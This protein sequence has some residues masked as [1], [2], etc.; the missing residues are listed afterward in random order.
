M[1]TSNYILSDVIEPGT[2][3]SSLHAPS[4]FA[5]R[6][7]AFGSKSSANAFGSVRSIASRASQRLAQAK[8]TLQV[9]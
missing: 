2:Y 9:L 3:K 8:P 6:V 5:S 4:P 7:S 1:L